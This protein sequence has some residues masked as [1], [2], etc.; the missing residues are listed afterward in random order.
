VLN[1]KAPE[2]ATIDNYQAVVNKYLAKQKIKKQEYDN[3]QDY[4]SEDM[5]GSFQFNGPYGQ[6]L[7]K[8]ETTQN[9]DFLHQHGLCQKFYSCCLRDLVI[10]PLAWR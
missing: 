9:E 8:F 7:V 4:D 5:L 3:N 10:V 1:K 2:E 6:H